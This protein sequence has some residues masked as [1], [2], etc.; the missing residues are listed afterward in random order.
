MCAK[1]DIN[2]SLKCFCDKNF[3]HSLKTKLEKKHD[4][5]DIK[6]NDCILEQD[7]TDVSGD[8]EQKLDRFNIAPPDPGQTVDLSH[9]SDNIKY[10]VH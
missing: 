6:P 7:Q 3:I 8:I 5:G 9:V 4:L 10:K 1:I 2:N